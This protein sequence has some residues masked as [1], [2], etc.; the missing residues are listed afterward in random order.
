VQVDFILAPLEFELTRRALLEVI[1]V[2]IACGAL[3]VLVVLR[4]LAFISDALAHCVVPGVVVGHLTR[5]S[6]ELW[7]G[8]AALLAAVS[9]GWLIR[10][11]L[12]GGDPAIAVVF[13]GA[14]ALGLAMISATGSYVNSLTEIMFG[15]VLAINETDL[16]ISALAALIVVLSLL[17]LFRPLVLATFDPT[18]TRA[19]G[20]PFGALDLMLYGMIALAVVSGMAAV[21]SILVTALIV[22]PAASARLLVRTVRSQMVLSASL[23]ALAGWIGLTVSFHWRVAS[24]GAIV[25]SAVVLFLLAVAVSP[26]SGVPALWTRRRLQQ[27]PVGELVHP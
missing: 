20:L 15:N 14:F 5:G 2:G 11:G 27:R 1:L 7:G 26:R 21:G 10:R 24:G 18:T 19:L 4:G 8:A 6:L 3:G 22:V 16:V 9:I 23:A 17:L 25:L 13:T 12:A